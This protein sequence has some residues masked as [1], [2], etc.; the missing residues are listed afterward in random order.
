M[1]FNSIERLEEWCVNGNYPSIHDRIF[2]MVEDNIRGGNV[3]DICCSTGL[4]GQRIQDELKKT[5]VGVDADRK[6]LQNARSYGV[7]VNLVEMKIDATN[8]SPLISVLIKN[9]IEVI[10]ARR[11][12]SEIFFNHIDQGAVFAERLLKETNVREIFIQGRREQPNA[13]HPIP[14]CSAEVALLGDLW[15]VEYGGFEMAY[16]REKGK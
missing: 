6:S 13:T 3:L 12:L 8:F 11:C 10:V 15:V 14:S 7:D 9:D 4:L 16:L 1:R 2:K 5:V